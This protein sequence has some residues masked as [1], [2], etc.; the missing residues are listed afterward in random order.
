MTDERVCLLVWRPWGQNN[1][2]A[3]K[4]KKKRKQGKQPVKASLSAQQQVL[5]TREIELVLKI[6]GAGMP[7]FDVV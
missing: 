7:G 2:K 6:F 5:R 4:K 1:Q 3:V